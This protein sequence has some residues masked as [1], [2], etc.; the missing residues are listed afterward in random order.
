M[1]ILIAGGGAVGGVVAHIFSGIGVEITLLDRDKAHLKAMREDGLNVKEGSE[2]RKVDIIISAPGE[3]EDL[4]DVVFLAVKAP[5]LGDTLREISPHMHK[6]TF[7]ISLQP[8]FA[9]E[10]VGDMV[11][12]KRA[13]GGVAFF[14]A[15]KSAPGWVEILHPGTL[16]L[17]ELDG[18]F[19]P[20]LQELKEILT[21]EKRDL[22]EITQNIKGHLWSHLCLSASLGSVGALTGQLPSKDLEYEMLE[23]LIAPLWREVVLVSAAEGAKLEAL[24][25]GFEPPVKIEEQEEIE[26]LFNLLTKGDRTIAEARSYAASMINDVG[27]KTATE[28]D[29]INGHVVSHGKKLGIK[30]PYNFALLTLIWEMERGERSPGTENLREMKRRAQEEGTMGLM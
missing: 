24:E 25:P 20:R 4:Y 3:L 29:F 11:E 28:V 26:A 12:L 10:L 7:F 5:K 22:L 16:V 1:R 9:M 19:S 13:V 18:I 30:T 27:E 6:D 23:E 21:H 15:R 14:S 8:G 17:G 2:I